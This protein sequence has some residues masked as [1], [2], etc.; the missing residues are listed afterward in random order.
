MRKT[1]LQLQE[2]LVGR[3]LCYLMASSSKVNIP[4][5]VSLT[6]LPKDSQFNKRSLQTKN[7]CHIVVL[8]A[9]RYYILL[10]KNQFQ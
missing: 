6:R 8:H 9:N 2:F 7:K 3:L 1:L 5:I 4:R 10:F